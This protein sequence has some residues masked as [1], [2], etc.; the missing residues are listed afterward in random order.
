M[1]RLRRRFLSRTV[2]TF[3][4][5]AVFYCLFVLFE[6]IRD[7]EINSDHLL[8]A[9]EV[10]KHFVDFPS[11]TSHNAKNAEDAIFTNLEP[12]TSYQDQERGVKSLTNLKQSKDDQYSQIFY[13][14]KEKSLLDCIDIKAIKIVENI[15]RG[16]TKTV[17]KGEHKGVEV[18]LKSVHLDNEDIRS[19]VSNPAAPRSI[20][21]CF[22]FAKYKLAKEI[23]MLQQLQHANIVKVSEIN[24]H[25]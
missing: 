9:S 25:A 17:Q 18:A 5:F 6:T 16:Y 15:G 14:T 10:N 11:L 2:L 24:Q 1:K 20:E 8:R 22:I 19:C 23:I 21:E 7:R 4:S 13:T 12:A 3:T